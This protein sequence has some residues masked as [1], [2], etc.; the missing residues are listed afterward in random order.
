MNEHYWPW[1]FAV[2]D[3]LWQVVVKL[4]CF[5]RGVILSGREEVLEVI[6][7]FY[8]RHPRAFILGLFHKYLGWQGLPVSYSFFFFSDFFFFIQNLQFI[9]SVHSACCTF[10]GFTK[11]HS[12]IY[13]LIFTAQLSHPY[14]TTGKT[15]AL[16][17]RTFVG[18]KLVMTRYVCRN[19]CFV[20]CKRS[21][22]MLALLPHANKHDL[23][24]VLIIFKFKNQM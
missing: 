11:M 17:R 5:Y 10:Y 2:S 12:D 18:K 9:F 1:L 16:T 19:P 21:A 20:Y 22:W 13:A 3:L 14:M 6:C 15:I 7:N 8:K 24:M 23:C 4:N